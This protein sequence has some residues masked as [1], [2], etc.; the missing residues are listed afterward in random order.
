MGNNET[1]Y[2]G[3]SWQYVNAY[4]KPVKPVFNSA[5]VLVYVDKFLIRDLNIDMEKRGR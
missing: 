5:L 3:Q 4:R 1:D 2:C